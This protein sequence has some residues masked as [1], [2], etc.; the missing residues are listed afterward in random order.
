MNTG[1]VA[2]PTAVY[3]T[4]TTL[5]PIPPTG[6]VQLRIPKWNPLA[7]IDSRESYLIDQLSNDPDIAFSGQGA[8]DNTIDLS[9]LCSSKLVSTSTF[10]KYFMLQADEI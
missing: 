4:I 9:K 10:H 2:R 1:I 7:P 3:F 5:N 8:E 6:G